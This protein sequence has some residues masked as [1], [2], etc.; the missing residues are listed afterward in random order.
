[1]IAA[2]HAGA[3]RPR[4][5]QDVGGQD[6]SDKR[7]DPRVV[8]VESMRPDVEVKVTVVPRTRE[9]ADEPAALHDDDGTSVTT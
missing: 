2:E 8:R 5:L 7:L 4:D 3:A 9:A 1:V 6:V